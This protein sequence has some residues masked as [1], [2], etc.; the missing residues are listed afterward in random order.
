MDIK[1]NE[2]VMD[3]STNKKN[4]PDKSMSWFIR[5]FKSIGLYI[6]NQRN[7]KDVSLLFGFIIVFGFVILSR[8]VKQDYWE[9]LIGPASVMIFTMIVITAYVR[10][11]RLMNE[12]FLLLCPK[13]KSKIPSIG[14][15]KLDVNGKVRTVLSFIYYYLSTYA[16]IAILMIVAFCVLF[17]IYIYY[18]YLVNIDLRWPGNYLKSDG[19]PM[20]VKIVFFILRIFFWIQWF[21]AAAP[22][23]GLRYMIGRKLTNEFDIP[24]PTP[25]P[26]SLRDPQAIIDSFLSPHGNLTQKIS[27]FYIKATPRA[28]IEFFSFT[29]KNHTKTHIIVFIIGLI[30]SITYSSLFIP[31]Y[32][33]QELCENEQKQLALK[34]AFSYG[35]FI[36]MAMIVAIYFCMIIR[37]CFSTNSD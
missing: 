20:W 34:N 10:G 36:V 25:P 24:D 14:L 16:R 3:N 4:D 18:F 5:I 31:V 29:Q 1:N 32:D 22:H 15:F 6:W 19:S 21:F 2:N 8:L 37:A 33:K 13:T 30:A 9:K 7:F 12:H 26:S 27:T 17:G 28:F 35:Y 23:Y 11:H